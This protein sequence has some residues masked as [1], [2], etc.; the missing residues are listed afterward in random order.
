VNYL[1]ERPTKDNA[2]LLD[3]SSATDPTTDG[4]AIRGQATRDRIVDAARDLLVEQGHGGTSTRAVADR[5]GVRLSL[6]HYHFG[7]KQGL[8]VE[9]LQRENDLLLERQRELFAAPGSLA[10]KWRVASDLLDEDIASGYVRVLWELWAAGLADA[11]LAEGWRAAT[12]GWR[13][14]IESVFETW[15]QERSIELPLRPR[16]L[17]SLL[18][19]VFQ[20]MEVEMLA[21]VGEDEAPHREVLD[22]IGELIARAESS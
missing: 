2:S 6:V 7:G 18:A 22:A 16:A 19:N 13:E 20:G 11:A 3:M 1:V 10:D 14:L 4:R 21:G 17:S 5:A 15:A 8:L 12:R 9:V